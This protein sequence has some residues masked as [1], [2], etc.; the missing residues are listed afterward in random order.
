LVEV[1]SSEHFSKTL[2]GDHHEHACTRGGAR[3]LWTRGT[4]AVDPRAA[5]G[6]RPYATNRPGARKLASPFAL[7][8]IILVTASRKR[9]VP[10]VFALQSALYFCAVPICS[11]CH[12]IC[13]SLFQNLVTEMFEDRNGPR[14]V[15]TLDPPY[16]MQPAMNKTP[17]NNKHHRPKHVALT[18]ADR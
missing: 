16:R 2:N 11:V 3:L 17:Y 18:R 5:V 8:A 13:I 15:L 7:P 10:T 14:W 12:R 9:R 6:N 1:F 4:L